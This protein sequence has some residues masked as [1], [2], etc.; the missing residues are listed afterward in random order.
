MNERLDQRGKG[1]VKLKGHKMSNLGRTRKRK[2]FV[3]EKHELKMTSR[4]VLFP[5]CCPLPKWIYV[6]LQNSWIF[7]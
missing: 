3:A 4:S 2:G 1:V 5:F 7:Q 6:L